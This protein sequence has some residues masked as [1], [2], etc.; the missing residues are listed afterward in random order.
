MFLPKYLLLNN[1]S[2]LMQACCLLIFGFRDKPCV[3]RMGSVTIAKDTTASSHCQLTSTLKKGK[4]QEKVI[5][6]SCAAGSDVTTY[7]V[8]LS[9]ARAHHW[10]YV[11]LSAQEAVSGFSARTSHQIDQLVQTTRSAAIRVSKGQEVHPQLTC[12]SALEQEYSWNPS[13]TPNMTLHSYIVWVAVQNGSQCNY[14]QIASFGIEILNSGYAWWINFNYDYQVYN[15]QYRYIEHNNYVSTTW[16][17]YWPAN[18]SP[19]W[20]TSP[21]NH[22]VGTIDKFQGSRLN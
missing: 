1:Q 13:S 4:V 15:E 10:S 9:V 19:E 17:T 8:P 20:Q 18:F 7:Q 16:N 2:L 14:V 3:P 5:H 22:Y 6:T 12:G 21:A 11:L